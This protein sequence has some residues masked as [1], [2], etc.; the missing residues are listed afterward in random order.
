VLRHRLQRKFIQSVREL[1][2]NAIITHGGPQKKL[3]LQNF[4]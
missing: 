3:Y 2:T 4:L 1:I